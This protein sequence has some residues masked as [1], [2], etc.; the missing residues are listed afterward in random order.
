[1]PG[2]GGGYRR[3]SS[4]KGEPFAVKPD[5]A[6]D[7]A[8]EIGDRGEDAAVEHLALQLGKPDLHL[9]EWGFRRR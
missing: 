1:M 3:T 8:A 9:I 2:H 6:H 7:L 5:V 4:E